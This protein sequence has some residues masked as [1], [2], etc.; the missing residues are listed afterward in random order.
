MKIY[1]LQKLALVDYPGKLAATVFTGGC[2]LRCPFCHNAP[3]V[4]QLTQTPA[5]SQEEVLSF[6]KQRQGLLDGVVLSGG[7]PL[8]QEDIPAFAAAVK[9]LGFTVKLDTNGTFPDRLEALL[10]AGLVD[11]V[12]MDIKN[13]LPKYPKTVGLPDFDPTPIQE[14]VNLLRH[15]RVNY[16]FRTTLIREFHTAADL[17]AIGAWLE[18]SPRYYLQAFVDSGNLIGS[19][20]SAFTPEEMQAFADQ[21]R[22]FFDRVEVR[23]V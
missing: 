19:G 10:N 8:L 6:L 14:S 13:S 15:S 16:E 9:T 22:P 17:Q 18:G 4:T 21:V 20:M 23:G 12:A 7:E 5:F 2:N 3:L 11:Y 1:G